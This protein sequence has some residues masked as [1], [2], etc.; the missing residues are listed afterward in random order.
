MNTGNARAKRRSGVVVN[1]LN[2]VLMNVCFHLVWVYTDMT[3]V[4]DVV[5]LGALAVVVITFFRVHRKTG[6]WQLTH[7]RADTLDERQLQITHNALSLSYGWFAVICLAIMM[8]HPVVYRL[9]PGLNFALSM[10]L[11][12]SLLYLAHTLPGS[13]LAWTETEVPG[14]AK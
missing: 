10:P 4:V 13:V 12:V 6:L 11:V 1:Y 7:A 8:T 14:G 5:G 3:H 9:V 2:L